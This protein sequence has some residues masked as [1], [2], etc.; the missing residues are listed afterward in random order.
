MLPDHVL[1][2]TV[3]PAQFLSPDDRP[4]NKAID[5]EFGGAAL[6]DPSQGLL[7]KVWTYR[8]VGDSAVT[9][10]ASDVAASTLFTRAGGGITEISG[11]FDQNMNPCVTFMQNG[12]LWLWW[13]DTFVVA[14]VFT[15]FDGAQPKVCMDDKRQ[16]QGAV[17]DMILAY[18]RNGDLFF[19][20]QRDRFGIEY[21]LFV[22]LDPDLTLTKIGMNKVNRVQ[23]AFSLLAGS[24]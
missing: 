18:V 1:S 11:C 12:Q 14:Q 13:F 5:Y 6:R 17:N 16:T 4:Y 24:P 7:V 8:L 10:E 15:S 9:V 21:P 20:A 22:G 2:T 19:R 3:I 23:F